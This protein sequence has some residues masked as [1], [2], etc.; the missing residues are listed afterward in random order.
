MK[1]LVTGG[2]GYLG[3]VLVD[4]LLFQHDVTVLDSFL[5]RENSLAHLC[6]W[7]RLE[8]IRGDVRDQRLIRDLVAKADVIIPLAALVGAPLCDQDRVGAHSTNLVAIQI[9]R[10][11]ASRDQPIIIPTTNSGY[12]IG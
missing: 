4:E 12:G 5:H 7:S 3:S 1:I 2:G 9:L 6:R 10:Q 11:E 8:I